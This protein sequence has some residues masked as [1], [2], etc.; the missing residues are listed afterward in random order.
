MLGILGIYFSVIFVPD[1]SYQS[2]LVHIDN[3]TLPNRYCGVCGINYCCVVQYDSGVH[4]SDTVR[5][6]YHPSTEHVDVVGLL[7]QPTER[8][9]SAAGFTLFVAV[10]LFVVAGVSCAE[11]EQAARRENTIDTHMEHTHVN[12][13]NKLAQ[14]TDTIIM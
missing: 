14:P 3:A 2:S 1:E 11:G 5:M 4:A 6:W 10:V 12:T 13:V 8:G 9:S 7:V